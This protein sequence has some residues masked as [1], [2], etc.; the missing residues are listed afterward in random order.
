MKKILCLLLMVVAI[1]VCKP[2]IAQTDTYVQI[3]FEVIQSSD[4]FKGLSDKLVTG[5]KPFMAQLNTGLLKDPSRSDE[6]IAKY[7]NQFVLDVVDILF[8]HD[9]KLTITEPEL[10]Q[11]GELI[12]S[13]EGKQYIAN[14]AKVEPKLSSIITNELGSAINVE[15]IKD[16]ILDLPDVKQSENIS[17]EYANKFYEY[18]TSGI[19]TDAYIEQISSIAFKD[20]GDDAT[21]NIK[22]QII[23]W[24]KNNLKVLVINSC[25][26]DITNDD[27]DFAEKINPLARKIMTGMTTALSK[28][29]DQNYSTNLSIQLVSRYYTWV[30]KQGIEINDIGI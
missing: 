7:G 2:V 6:V 10:K 12:K 3:L 29:S 30:E 23:V 16:G 21:K 17:A 20:N 18:V 13:S 27:L 24:L 8:T 28:L 22:N 19:I 26:E 11:Y 25:Y 15:N 14:M 9:L 5:F 4:K 1:M